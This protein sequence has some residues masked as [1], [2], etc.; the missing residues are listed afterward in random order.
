MVRKNRSQ[1]RDSRVPEVESTLSALIGEA[2]R[3]ELGSSRRATKTV[4]RWTGVSDTTARS[5]LYGHGSP[6]GVHLVA[7]AANSRPVLIVL[8]RL[9]GHDDLVIGLKLHEVEQGLLQVIEQ[10]RDIRGKTIGPGRI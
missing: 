7:L 6:S 3:N 10:V 2:L 4:M 5:W 8:L 1:L 9:T